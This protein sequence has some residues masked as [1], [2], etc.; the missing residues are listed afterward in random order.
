MTHFEDTTARNQ[1]EGTPERSLRSAICTASAFLCLALG[2][3][4]GELD[5]GTTEPRLDPVASADGGSNPALFPR[6]ELETR[7]RAA[8]CQGIAACCP[9]YHAGAC[10]A[11]SDIVDFGFGSG[12]LYDPA[13]ALSC[14]EL[15]SLVTAECGKVSAPPADEAA[16]L[17]AQDAAGTREANPCDRVL[18]GT[19]AVGEPCAALGCAVATEPDRVNRCETMEDGIARCRAHRYGARAGDRCTPVGA[20]FETDTTID[21]CGTGRYAYAPEALFDGELV[22]ERTT[23]TCVYARDVL[24]GIG[25]PCTKGC[26]NGLYCAGA[27]GAGAGTCQARGKAGEA[28]VTAPCAAGLFCNH[29]GSLEASCTAQL[30]D[31]STCTASDQCLGECRNKVCAPEPSFPTAGLC[32]FDDLP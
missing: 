14:V 22:C 13:A 26:R 15:L 6:E 9:V 10:E 3:C 2:A 28:C 24:G 12:P 18:Y 23:A 7:A 8:F 20:A 31:L 5:V 1:H 30:P 11:Q 27:A 4:S 25:D 29:A 19:A 32:T 21:Y 16:A 17:A